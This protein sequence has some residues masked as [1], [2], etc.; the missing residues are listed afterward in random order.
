MILNVERV[1][2]IGASEL[3]QWMV[4]NEGKV[5]LVASIGG[6]RILL[7]MTAVEAKEIGVAAILAHGQA[8]AIEQHRAA[9]AAPKLH[10]NGNKP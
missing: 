3:V 2:E 9:S 7:E 5:A 6:Q 1:L 4:S 10:L 8:S